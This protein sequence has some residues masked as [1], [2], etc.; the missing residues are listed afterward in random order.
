MVSPFQTF[1][2]SG[3]KATGAGVG[4]GGLGRLGYGILQALSENLQIKKSIGLVLIW[5]VGGRVGW[6]TWRWRRGGVAAFGGQVV[7]FVV[8][9]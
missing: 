6:G 3:I 5:L 4:V 8:S 1:F 7:V 2:N 9:E